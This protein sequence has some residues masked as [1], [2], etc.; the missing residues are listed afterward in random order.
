MSIA[1]QLSFSTATSVR[2]G[3]LGSIPYQGAS[4]STLFVSI[5]AAGT[6]LTSNGTA[7]IWAPAGGTTVGTST[8][9]N[10]VL[11]TASNAYYL[12]FVDSNNAVS[13]AE[14]VYT[15]STFTINPATGFVG[16]GSQDG[17]SPLNVKVLST[18]SGTINSFQKVFTT[19]ASGG[20]GNNVYRSEWR[21][22]RAAGTD[23]VTQNIHDGIWVDGSFT[24][25]GTDTRTWW[26]RDPNTTSQAWGD[27][28]TTWMFVNSTGLGIRHTN[29]LH[30][31]HVKSG[32]ASGTLSL[33][34]GAE[35]TGGASYIIMGNNDSGGVSGPTVILSAN[36]TLQFGH[37]TSFTLAG[38]GTFTSRMSITSN[39]GI[40]FGASTSNYGTA[41]QV[42]QS[43][44][45]A[46]PTWVPVS[47][48]TVGT[49]TQVTTI[50]RA[51]NGEHHL[52]FVDSNNASAT[53]ESVYTTSSFTINPF[54][55]NIQ[56][57]M[58]Y[59]D[60]QPASGGNHTLRL[61][62]IN[63]SSIGFHDSGSTIANIKFSGA[64]GFEIGAADGL[65]GPHNTILHGNVGIGTQSPAAKLHVGLTGSANMATTTIS[66]LTNVTSTARAGFGGLANNSDG[67]YFG[68]GLDGGICA[69]LGLFRE[70]T[71]WNSAIAFYTNNITDGTN[72]G[73]FQEKMRIT[74]NGGISFGAS[75]TAYGT[76]GQVLQSNGDAPPTWVPVSGTTVGTST[77]VT[78]VLRTTAAAHFLTFVDSNNAAATAETVYTTSSFTI[79]PQSGNVMIGTGTPGAPLSF[80]DSL[81]TKIQLNANA[82][83]S[84][85][86]GKAA[87]V[88]SGDS[89][90]KFVAGATAAGEF[91][92][93]NT[94]NLRLLIN[95]N[96][97]VL[98]NRS[99][100][101]GTTR[102]HVTGGTTTVE[103]VARLHK[104]NYADTG[105]HTT[106]LGFG[107]EDSG[108]SKTAIGHTRTSSYDSGYFGIYVSND[109]ISGTDA[110][111]ST[112]RRVRVDGSGVEIA[113][114]L[115][116]GT[117][118]SGV[119]GE[120]RATNEITAYY[121]SDIRLKENI[122]LIA[123]PITIVNQI[124]G[125]YYDWTDEHIA[126]R[127]GE[128]GYF[129]RKH[130]I[131]VIAQEVEKVL[132]EIVATR[133]DGTKV[134]KYEKLVALL[135]EAV[136][137]QQQQINQISQ[138]LQ[139]LAIK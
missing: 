77:Q 57:G 32:A 114:A 108:W 7:P 55:G 27:Q 132:P 121:S 53:A 76:A 13:T 17:G 85:T 103:Y 67:V 42:L 116:V 105:G 50:S 26:E 43:N 135:I 38:G 90:T 28:A 8:Q 15:T 25:P 16:I 96:G 86:I 92:F 60:Y 124:R 49:S 88:N 137:D 45:D 129:V 123:D 51:F 112:H 95:N 2:G 110:S 61:N 138:A 18:L 72:V 9:V 94:T 19:Q 63:T 100:Q 29:P 130:D 21:R 71:G 79:N 84:Y 136:K 134:V 133:D 22:R 5:G 131:G 87:G 40:A 1:S 98:I 81:T 101:V 113:N 70:A 6:V 64:Y 33:S 126:A 23:W 119:T 118:A 46:A 69:G 78:T 93:Y 34:G 36:R 66:S 31:L 83:N 56:I 73:R 102:L 122:R 10:T 99:T 48:T 35:A 30:A 12:T 39:G 106:L 125:V 89:M 115:G 52:A 58:V 97:A 109:V 4:S 75:R 20:V 111:T 128:D 54:T 59:N 139:N 82:A 11:Q 3:A 120:I 104:G 47:G 41:G 44:G 14:A 74:S 117:P 37:G 65:Y 107:C 68:T 127:G 62:A 24:T 80:T 91:G